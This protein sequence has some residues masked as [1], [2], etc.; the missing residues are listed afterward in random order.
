MESLTLDLGT[1]LDETV[2]ILLLSYGLRIR[3]AIVK[4]NNSGAAEQLR[5]AGLHPDS[6]FLEF[7]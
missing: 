5:T 4:V 2:N 3:I 1:A 6:F 7:F